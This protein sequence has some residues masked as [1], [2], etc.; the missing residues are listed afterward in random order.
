MATNSKI[1]TDY[2]T[3]L[4]ELNIASL[5]ET[6]LGSVR[7][8]KKV[9]Y[10][11]KVAFSKR[12]RG[13][14]KKKMK[15]VKIQARSRVW[16]SRQDG[17]PLN[18]NNAATLQIVAYRHD[19]VWPLGLLNID[20]DQAAGSFSMNSENARNSSSKHSKSNNNILIKSYTSK[21]AR[22]LRAE[23]ISTVQ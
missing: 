16:G 14:L 21:T 11:V 20:P 6:G 23:L 4:D 15:P 5:I 8:I 17:T 9:T 1:H 2:H 10:Q 7:N 13:K 3:Q 18:K 22:P 19:L 12:R